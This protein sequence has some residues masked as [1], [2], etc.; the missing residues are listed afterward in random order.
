[1]FTS[2]QRRACS[3]MSACAAET[4]FIVADA[5]EVKPAEKRRVVSPAS[6]PT[7]EQAVGNHEHGGSERAENVA[8]QRAGQS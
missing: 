4:V 2:R 5:Y 3:R 7:A 6:L 8:H 1:M